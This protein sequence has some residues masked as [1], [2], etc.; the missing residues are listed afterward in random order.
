VSLGA[1]SAVHLG[2]EEKFCVVVKKENVRDA[3]EK[4]MGEGEENEKIRERARKYA[5]LANDA[6]EEGGSS[7]H[8]MTQ[9]IEDI[10]HVQ[11][12]C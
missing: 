2:E 9:L 3:I 1:Q 6:L 8:N 11:S 10:M 5:D 4:V 7:Y 12:L